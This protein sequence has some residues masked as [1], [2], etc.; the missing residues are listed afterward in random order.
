MNINIDLKA[1]VN[2]TIDE[3]SAVPRVVGTHMQ[4]FQYHLKTEV[5]VIK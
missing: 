4:D 3:L 2:T 1:E 5:V